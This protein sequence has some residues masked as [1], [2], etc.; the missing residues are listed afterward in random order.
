MIEENVPLKEEAVSNDSIETSMAAD[1]DDGPVPVRHRRAK[2]VYAGMWGPL[3]ITAVGLALFLLL[4]AIG[5]YLG[6]VL[7]ENRRLED[8]RAR[9]D[10]VEK[11]LNEAKRK[12]GDISNTETQVNKLIAS[13]EDFE[14]RFLQEQSIGKTAIYQRLNGLISAFGLINSTGPD[15]TPIEVSEDDRRQG[16]NERTERG[17]SKFQSL[18][19]GIYVTMTVEGPYV[20]LR[21]FLSDIENSNEFV[22][23]STIELE[24]S[25]SKDSGVSPNPPTETGVVAQTVKKTDG[26]RTRGTI[27]SLRLEL[28]AYFQR[29]NEQRILTASQPGAENEAG[30]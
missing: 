24:P 7:P 4:A 14:T 16:S 13:A 18:Y 15:Y 23:I 8:T 9:R 10:S 12:F 26:G 20:N 1:H 21:R 2:K 22:V 17:R 3:E 5:L 27:V 19:P 25:E 28:A 11:D 30:Q 29:P 6:F